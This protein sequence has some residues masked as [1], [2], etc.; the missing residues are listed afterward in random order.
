MMLR[1]QR[2]KL[3][4]QGR[5]RIGNGRWLVR[6]AGA[7]QVGGDLHGTPCRLHLSAGRLQRRNVSMPMIARRHVHQPATETRSGG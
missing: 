5:A 3:V 4:E 1:L 7:Q 6:A 2:L